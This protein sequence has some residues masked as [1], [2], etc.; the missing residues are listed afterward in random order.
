[1][2]PLE[3]LWSNPL[4]PSRDTQRR[5]LR[6]TSR[7]VFG[8]L[9]RRGLHNLSGYPLQVLSY[10]IMKCKQRRSHFKRNLYI[11][12]QVF[13]TWYRFPFFQIQFLTAKKINED[14]K[15][16]IKIDTFIHLTICHLHNLINELNFLSEKYLTVLQQTSRNPVILKMIQHI[17]IQKHPS[18]QA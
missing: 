17:M 13:L 7:W 4:N 9:R 14:W 1:M 3:V 15:K 6:T 2:G 10:P 5:Q 18:I 11:P 12:L 16:K 8:D